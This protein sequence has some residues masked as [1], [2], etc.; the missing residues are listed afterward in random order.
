MS[1]ETAPVR[2]LGWGTAGDAPWQWG[3][4]DGFK[5]FS[6]LAPTRGRGIVALTNSAGGQ[7]V[8]REWVNAWLGTDLPA[9]FFK[10]VEL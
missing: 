6:A 2:R 3:H 8:N 10:S 9:F 7:R 1:R 4:S 5:A